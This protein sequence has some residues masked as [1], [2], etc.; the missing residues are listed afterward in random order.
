MA[1]DPNRW[2]LKTTEAFSAATELARAASHPEVVPEHLLMALL[3]QE[4]GIVLPLL[5]RVG[6]DIVAARN[7]HVA[8]II[9]LAGTGVRG[10]ELLCMQHELIMRVSG[11]SEEKIAAGV[12]T[13]RAT[14]DVV[15]D[16][17]ISADEARA[18]MRALI[19]ANP[20]Y[21]AA[22]EQEQETTMQVALTQLASPWVITF[23]RHDPRP[24]LEQ[25]SCPVLALCGELDV[26]VPYEANLAEI[27]AALRRGGNRDIT[28]RSFPGMNH[29]FQHAT[30]GLVEE[31]G[32]IE[33]TFAVE[34]LDLMTDW[35]NRRFSN[36]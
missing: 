23:A 3:G 34:V 32:Q 5:H 28:T 20:D 12:A 11:E 36:G 9:M 33:E 29:L 27:R 1:L 25:V 2:T 35:I 6:V 22:T 10:D 24:T 19:E 4:E 21:Q 7:E 18:R 8:F 17:S 14:L 16:E 26:Q 15:I 31:Y 30:T 13:Q